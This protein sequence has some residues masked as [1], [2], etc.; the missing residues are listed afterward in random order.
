MRNATTPAI[1]VAVPAAK[2]AVPMVWPLM[3]RVDEVF[4][5]PLGA[6]VEVLLSVAKRRHAVFG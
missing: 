6:G 2:V 5:L 3:A 4:L 1:T